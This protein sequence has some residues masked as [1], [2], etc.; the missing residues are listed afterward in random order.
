MPAGSVIGVDLGG[1]K[2]A[3]GLVDR[4]GLVIAEA[5]WPR[6]VRAYDDAVGAI[7]ALAGA[8]RQEA[9]DRG[10]RVIGAGVAAAGLFD[11]G[12]TRVLHAPPTLRLE[13]GR[14]SCRERVWTVV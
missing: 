14:A 11:A 12:R 1:T 13:I 2:L 7:E 4:H 5:R 6:R 9:A 8:L 10:E 3:A